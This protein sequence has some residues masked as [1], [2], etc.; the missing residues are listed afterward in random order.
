MPNTYISRLLLVL[1]CLPALPAA[2]PAAGYADPPSAILISGHHDNNASG[3]GSVIQEGSSTVIDLSTDHRRFNTTFNNNHTAGMDV[4]QGCSV[5]VQGGQFNSNKVG[6]NLDRASGTISGG[7]FDH[8]AED[9]VLANAPGTGLP[10]GSTL[11]VTG[12]Q[13]HGNNDAGLEVIL[14]S[15]TVSDGEFT[16][17]ETGL[18]ANGATVTLT[19]GTFAKNTKYGLDAGYGSTISVTGG[20]FSGNTE[21]DLCANG[22]TITLTGTFR[23][24]GAALSGTLTG[25]GVFDALFAGSTQWQT[26]TYKAVNDGK[27]MLQPDLALHSVPS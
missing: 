11:T 9:G 3:A 12:G 10:G 4:R 21:A 2:F 26:L 14:S 27:I 7:Q 25:T 24:K 17:N 5:T 15:A 16:S 23:Q 13:F 22:G 8:N 18:D 19:G 6:L 20:T 1:V